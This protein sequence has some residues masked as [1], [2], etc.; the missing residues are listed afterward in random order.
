[1]DRTKQLEYCKKC[2]KQKFDPR[3]GIICSLTNQKADF[4]S[5]CEHFEI[6]KAKIV[7]ETEKQ[8]TEKK[9]KVS[10]GFSPKQIDNLPISDLN[11]KQ[12]FVLAFEA[13]K[14]LNWNV[15]Y[16]SESGFIA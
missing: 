2:T 7:I 6:D 9:S 11:K 14:R 1:M 15:G 3:Q 4:E 12:L 5:E 8:K 16:L 10:F 13:V